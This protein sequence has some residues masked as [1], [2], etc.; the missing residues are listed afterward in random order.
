MEN[1]YGELEGCTF[2]ATNTPRVSDQG[3]LIVGIPASFVLTRVE[4]GFLIRGWTTEWVAN[5]YPGGGS[6]R[7]LKSTGLTL[8]Q[9]EVEYALK[10]GQFARMGTGDRLARIERVPPSKARKR[11]A[12][13]K[14]EAR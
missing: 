12:A 2:Y 9:A 1:D 13:H 5:G 4:K 8:T 7:V 10:H 11:T 3:V 14:K 6:R